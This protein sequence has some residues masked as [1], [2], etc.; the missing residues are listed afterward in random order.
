MTD[1]PDGWDVDTDSRIA[2]AE[3]IDVALIA[4]ADACWDVFRDIFPT[5]SQF[6]PERSR[7]TSDSIH[8]LSAFRPLDAVE[9]SL[10]ASRQ[11]SLVLCLCEHQVMH[12]D[13]PAA[14][15]EDL[16]DA[17]AQMA[18]LATLLPTATG[19]LPSRF[20]Y[21]PSLF[22]GDSPHVTVEVTGVPTDVAWNGNILTFAGEC[23]RDRI[24]DLARLQGTE[25]SSVHIETEAQALRRLSSVATTP[26]A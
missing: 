12:D 6:S 24:I 15:A 17:R 8:S 23:L 16:D 9:L 3:M 18:A 11:E 21:I 14:L 5:I 13:L 10:A 25:L 19:H 2:I 22:L 26:T 4:G 7:A 20:G 1:T